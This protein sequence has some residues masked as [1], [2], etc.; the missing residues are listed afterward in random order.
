[1]LTDIY[2]QSLPNLQSLLANIKIKRVLNLKI[3]LKDFQNHLTHH[4]ELLVLY[5]SQ[6][7]LWYLSKS[8]TD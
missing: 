7:I 4:S 5:E 8:Y 1:M 6:P 3:L 2:T